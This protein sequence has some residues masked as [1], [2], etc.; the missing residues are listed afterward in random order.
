MADSKYNSVEITEED[1]ASL[2][3]PE[4]SSENSTGVKE[5]DTPKSEE[6]QE[7]EQDNTKEQDEVAF[8]LDGESYSA[9]DVQAWMKDSQNKEEWQKSNT[10]KAQDLSKWNKLTEKISQDEKFREYLGEYF[11]DNPD[12]LDKIG[13]D[14]KTAPLEEGKQEE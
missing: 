4:E 6:T 5:E 2:S 14:G 11:Y 9:E 1:V 10:Q 12:E 7:K 3:L 13:L 8:E